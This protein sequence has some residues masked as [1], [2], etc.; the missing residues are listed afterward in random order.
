MGSPSI[1]VGQ[2]NPHS[3]NG[4]L[5]KATYRFDAISTKI[6]GTFFTV[7]ENDL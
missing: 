1:L 5:T 4:C 7:V 6:P 2:K 3:P